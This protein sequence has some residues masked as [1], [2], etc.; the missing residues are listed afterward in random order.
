MFSLKE[1]RKIETFEDLETAQRWLKTRSLFHNGLQNLLVT[2]PIHL[3]RVTKRLKDHITAQI[4]IKKTIMIVFV[5]TCFV[6][7]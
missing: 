4:Y 6:E 2:A 1:N 7:N 3:T 5:E